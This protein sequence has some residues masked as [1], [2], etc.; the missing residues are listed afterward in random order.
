MNNAEAQKNKIQLDHQAYMLNFCQ[1]QMRVKDE[2]IGKY[3]ALMETMTNNIVSLA[4]KNEIQHK[5][6]AELGVIIK[7]LC[8]KL[9]IDPATVI[10]EYVEVTNDPAQPTNSS[11]D[12]SDQVS[13]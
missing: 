11:K 9:N 4:R 5:F 7:D 1:E 2:Q 10:K 13:L 3:L 8:E 12:D 6:I